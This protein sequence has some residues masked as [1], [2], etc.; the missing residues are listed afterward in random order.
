[1]TWHVPMYADVLVIASGMVRLVCPFLW[2][3]VV[4]L[5]L[6]QARWFCSRKSVRVPEKEWRGASTY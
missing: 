3:A 4:V 1:N 6:F 2:S 5:R